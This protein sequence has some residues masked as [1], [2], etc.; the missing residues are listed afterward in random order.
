MKNPT[1]KISGFKLKSS[2]TDGELTEIR[3]ASNK[4]I[5]RG[6]RQATMNIILPMQRLG[7]T[8]TMFLSTS[9][10][11]RT[12]LLLPSTLNVIIILSGLIHEGCLINTFKVNN[13]GTLTWADEYVEKASCR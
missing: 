7:I 6:L 10:M 8:P 5:I 12:S 3:Y 13:G 2:L 1:L 11:I 4:M 9:R